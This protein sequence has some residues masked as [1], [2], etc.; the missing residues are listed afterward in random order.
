S[1]GYLHRSSPL[2]RG[3]AAPVAQIS[4]NPMARAGASV[5]R[6]PA[7]P[8]RAVGS[9]NVRLGRCLHRVHLR[10]R[11]ELLL[12]LIAAAAVSLALEVAGRRR[13]VLVDVRAADAALIAV[14]CH[15]R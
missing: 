2:A 7:C 1:L 13:I 3:P 5:T 15:V 9:L 8:I 6:R 14:T 11:F 12:A 10:V 4:A